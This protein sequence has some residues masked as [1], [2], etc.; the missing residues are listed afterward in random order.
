MSLRLSDNCRSPCIR[1]F[2]DQRSSSRRFQS[3]F[4][5]LSLVAPGLKIIDPNKGIMDVVCNTTFVYQYFKF[6]AVSYDFG[7]TENANLNIILYTPFACKYL[8]PGK[9][10]AA[11]VPIEMRTDRKSTYCTFQRKDFKEY[12]AKTKQN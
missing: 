3:V 6:C 8:T 2:V 7:L 5:P 11:I 10:D 12:A 9:R 4:R 1:C